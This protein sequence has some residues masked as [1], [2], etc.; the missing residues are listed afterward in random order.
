MLCFQLAQVLLIS[1][2]PF[3]LAKQ[4]TPLTS[5]VLKQRRHLRT[6]EGLFDVVIVDEAGQGLD[7]LVLIP[8]LMAKKIVLAGGTLS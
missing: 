3:M 5:F 8:L 2:Q 4:N 7:P 6:Y 1:T